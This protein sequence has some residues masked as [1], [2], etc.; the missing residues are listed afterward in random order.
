MA[1]LPAGAERKG[2]GS[3]T[4]R[5][6]RFAGLN[7]PRSSWAKNKK[8]AVLASD[9][10]KVKLIHFGDSRYKHNYSDKARNNYRNRSAGITDG[11]GRK[12]ANNKLSANYWAR[13]E[14]W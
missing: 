2:D 10:D 8:R 6:K 4:Y 7:K 14:L 5:G 13:K 9:G 11:A 1:K 12:T 3:I